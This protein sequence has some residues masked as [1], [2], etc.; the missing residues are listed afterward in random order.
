MESKNSEKPQEDCKYISSSTS[1]Q[2]D[3][4][5]T[6]NTTNKEVGV[7]K[8]ILSLQG[9]IT[10]SSNAEGVIFSLK[11]NFLSLN[12]LMSMYTLNYKHSKNYDMWFYAI[13]K[14][15]I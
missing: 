14:R 5:S 13:K 6:N 3:N 8:E 9:K 7:E 11:S 1:T 15:K 12:V 4:D 10:N 2:L